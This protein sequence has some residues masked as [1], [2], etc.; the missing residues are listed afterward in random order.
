LISD[1]KLNDVSCRLNGQALQSSRLSAVGRIF[2][3]TEFLKRTGFKLLFIIAL[4]TLLRFWGLGIKQLWLD[5]ILQLLHS[6][7]DSLRGILEGVAQDRGGAPLDYLIQHVFISNLH[8]AIEW[9]ARFHAALFGV[10]AVWLVY[11]VCRMLFNDPRW[12]LTGALLFCFYPFAHHYSQEGRPYS[13]F[14]L[15]TLILYLIFIRSLKKNSW[16]VW[17]SFAVVALMAFYTHAYTALVLFGQL[18]FLIYH[19]L[20][21]REDWPAAFRRGACFIFCSA[22]AA[23]AYVPW[24][25]YSF[26]NAKGNAPPGNGFRLFLELIKGLGDGSYPLAFA[27]ILCAAA[28]VYHLK[29]AQ[30]SLELGILLLWILTPFP[31]ILAILTWRNYFFA[32]RQF[33]FVTPALIILAAIGADY[34]KQKISR[35]YFSPQIIL[36]VIS[37]VVIALHYRDKREDLR[38][39]GQFLKQSAR[40]EVA[41]VSPGLT[42][43]LTYYFP[44]IEKYSADSIPPQDLMRAPGRSGIIYVDSRFNYERAGLNELLNSMPKPEEIRFR[45]ITIYSFIK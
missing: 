40:Q 45:G 34:L 38:S 3:K 26:F 23:A 1:K 24:L 11:L 41:I 28:G 33:I 36:I 44:E 9:T 8:G 43:T 13:L 29:K 22:A 42:Y 7:P 37:I 39:V 4:A 17:T 15:L 16:H 2:M 6:R 30:R 35:R 27:L 10:L 21:K 12:S 31:L 5:E 19:Q 18:L 25:R 32:S 14:L 20:L